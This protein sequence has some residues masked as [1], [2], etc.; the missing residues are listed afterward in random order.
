MRSTTIFEIEGLLLNGG[1]ATS[2]DGENYN[3]T[4]ELVKRIYE[5]MTT[6]IHCEITHGGDRV[7]YVHKWWLTNG[8]MDIGYN[9]LIYEPSGIVAIRDEGF[10]AGSPDLELFRDDNGN[11]VDGHL[12]SLAFVKDPAMD[13]TGLQIIRAAFSR[14]QGDSSMVDK[15]EG[16]S[17][18]TDN[19]DEEQQDEEENIDEQDQT[20]QTTDDST[21][22][23]ASDDTPGEPTLKDIMNLLKSEREERKK[24]QGK[25]DSVVSANKKLA[26]SQLEMLRADVKALGFDVAELTRGLNDKQAEGVLRNIK[27]NMAGKR[28]LSSTPG[29][30]GKPGGTA[31]QKV[32]ETFQGAL[33]FLGMDEETYLELSGKKKVE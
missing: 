6:G 22:D 16:E 2:N 24:L 9:A 3:F 15:K 25:L 26:N 8:G 23:D 11:I 21:D 32:D 18:E 10:S 33:K 1:H 12:K 20:D 30:T 28:S 7:G 29:K 17:Q 27:S 4:P 14:Q 31:R 19:L 13:N 5:N